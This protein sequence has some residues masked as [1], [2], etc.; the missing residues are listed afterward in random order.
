MG[1]YGHGEPRRF[2]MPLPL[3][4]IFPEEDYRF[5]LTLRKGNLAEFFQATE[6]A[7]LSERRAWL[8]RDPGRYAVG[9]AGAGVLLSEFET[10]IGTGNETA[11]TNAAPSLDLTK[12]LIQRGGEWEPDFVLLSN[13]HAGV[14]RIRG[15]VVCFPSW[16]DLAEK[17]GLTL[18]KTHGP[19]PGLNP[20]LGPTLSQFLQKLKPGV[21][22]ERA[23]WGLAATPDLNLH[24]ALSA[25]RLGLPFD[26]ERSWV[27]IEDQ[28]LAALPRTGGIVFGIRLRIIPLP[29]LLDEPPLR[30]G[31]HRALATLS[32]PLAAY[33]GLSPVLRDLLRVTS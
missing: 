5:Q 25:P 12:R 21:A 6:P 24:P 16:W 1:S 15:G 31:L 19:V 33:K 32:E 26:P 8:E 14:F 9:T 2:N 13:E 11:A 3:T 20:S 10:I 4:E 27:R 29:R 17:I 7:L 23:N 22:Y 18:D 28:I 30:A